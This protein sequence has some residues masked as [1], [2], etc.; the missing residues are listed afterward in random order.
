MYMYIINVWMSRNFLHTLLIKL[1]IIEGA[2]MA[3]W[4]L[5]WHTIS[6]S[7]VRITEGPLVVLRRASLLHYISEAN[8][9][10]IHCTKIYHL[11]W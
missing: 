3:Q 7:V 5:Q 1:F 2:V 11:W 10:S 9:H 8:G 4:L 6:R